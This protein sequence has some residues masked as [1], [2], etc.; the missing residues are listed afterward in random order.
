MSFRILLILLH[1]GDL[2]WHMQKLSVWGG[3]AR[4]GE[5]TVLVQKNQSR[6]WS[7]SGHV[8]LGHR[9]SMW[10]GRWSVLA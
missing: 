8:M 1:V 6:E 2:C 3:D 7:G 5:P 4:L 9:S 10:S